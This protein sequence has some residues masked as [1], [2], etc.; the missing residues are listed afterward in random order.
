MSSIVR[1]PVGDG[2]LLLG[3]VIGSSDT[4]QVQANSEIRIT[5]YLDLQGVLDVIGVFEIQ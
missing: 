1:V 2:S 4:L 3:S 5:N